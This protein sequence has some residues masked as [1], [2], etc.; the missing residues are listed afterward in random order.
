MHLSFFS[1][2]TLLDMLRRAGFSVRQIRHF[3]VPNDW[4]HSLRRRLEGHRATA[5]MARTLSH[6]N[7]FWSAL[8]APLGLACAAVHTSARI[9][10]QAG[11]AANPD[12]SQIPMHLS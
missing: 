1:E 11:A 3:M 8:F 6:R 12:F 9:E 7:L 5:A 10:I 4:I 2:K